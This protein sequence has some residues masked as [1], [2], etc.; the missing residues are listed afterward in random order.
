METTQTIRK[1]LTTSTFDVFEKMFFIFLELSDKGG[2]RYDLMTSIGFTGPCAGEINLGFSESLARSMVENMLGL[3]REEITRAMMEDCAKE[4]VNM[5]GGQ[6][7]RTLDATKVFNMTMPVCSTDTVAEQ[8]EAEGR[9]CQQRL[10]FECEKGCL[11][12]RAWMRADGPG[13]TP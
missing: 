7:L 6:F 3:K 2:P 10:N 1:A 5:I 11:R 4:A 8:R 13:T 12:V 9:D